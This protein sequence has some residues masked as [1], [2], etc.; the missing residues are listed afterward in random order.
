MKYNFQLCLK[1]IILIHM[2]NA[3]ID[4][5]ECTAKFNLLNIIYNLDVDFT[6]SIWK[7]NVIFCPFGFIN[8]CLHRSRY[9][10]V[11]VS[12]YVFKMEN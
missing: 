1:F 8:P 7:W 12:V 10:S 2:P 4:E 5:I 3:R 6:G 11:Y 9:G